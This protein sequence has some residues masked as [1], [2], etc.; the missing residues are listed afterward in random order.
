MKD[1]SVENPSEEDLF[2][3]ESND[4]SDHIADHLYY[5]VGGAAGSSEESSN[6]G[7]P[8]AETP[9]QPPPSSACNGGRQDPVLPADDFVDEDHPNRP[10]S[11]EEVDLENKVRWQAFEIEKLQ[12]ILGV[13]VESTEFLQQKLAESEEE[14]AK[15]R[16]GLQRFLRFIVV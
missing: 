12:S 2:R 3:A 4:R 13:Y 8:R 15:V 1:G 10:A 11:S 6:M 14:K 9:S 16:T 7:R 5:R